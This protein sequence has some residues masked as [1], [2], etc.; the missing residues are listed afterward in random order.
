MPANEGGHEPGQRGGSPGGARSVR[1]RDMVTQRK[2]TQL[3]PASLLTQ[4]P[5]HVSCHATAYPST[6]IQ[7]DGGNK[8]GEQKVGIKWGEE[9]I[10]HHPSLP[11][12]LLLGECKSERQDIYCSLTKLLWWP[13]ACLGVAERQHGKA[14]SSYLLVSH[15]PCPQFTSNESKLS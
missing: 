4:G 15:T 5:R 11:L 12:P 2:Q 8:V 13:S 9:Q 6:Q 7:A 14:E 3:E 1:G 10:P